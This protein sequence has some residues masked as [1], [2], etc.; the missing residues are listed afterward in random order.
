[1]AVD[2][3]Y[4]YDKQENFIGTL[5][6][7]N[8]SMCPF[9]ADGRYERLDNTASTL[10][11][12]TLLKHSSGI[13]S[14][15]ENEGFVV[16]KDRDGKFV[17]YKIIIA[18]EDRTSRQL[19]VLAVGSWIELT[20]EMIEPFENVKLSAKQQLDYF[21]QNTRWRS[22][23]VAYNGVKTMSSDKMMTVLEATQRLRTTFE[24]EPRFRI[25]MGVNGEITGRYCD[26]L[27][28]RGIVHPNRFEI[29]KDV[30]LLKRKID[31]T[32]L[33]TALYGYGQQAEGSN[34]DTP[35]DFSGV[36][37]S[38]SNGDPVNKPFG[39]KWVG[40]DEALAKYGGK[41]KKHRFGVHESQVQGDANSLLQHTWEVLQRRSVPKV[42]YEVDL[43]VLGDVGIGDTINIVDQKDDDN[44]LYLEARV[45]E[46]EGPVSEDK[47]GK[48]ILGNYRELQKPDV[49]SKIKQLEKI[50]GERLLSLVIASIS[51]SAGNI[52]K[53]GIG[54]T[55][56]TANAFL[57]GLE[58]DAD[59]TKYT[60]TWNKHD[61][62]GNLVPSFIK[63][64]KTITVN[65]NEI[66][67]KA[68][69][70]VT[71]RN[72]KVSIPAEITISNVF[73]G[74]DGKDG[75]TP[76][77][78]VDYFDGVDGQNGKDGSSSF[79]WIRYSQNADGSNMTTDPTGAKYIGVS[80]TK[81]STAPTNN[82][83]YQWSLVKGT[84]GVKG[85]KGADGQT[86]YLHIKYSND[87]GKTF[88]ANSGETVGDWIGTYVDF[89]ELDSTNVTDYT[90]NKVKGEQ[91]PQ[92]IPGPKGAD[93]QTLYT[94]I[95]YANDANG[96]GMSDY[97]DG[98]SYIG[99]AYN[100][101]TQT[102]STNPADYQWALIEG[103]QGVKGTDGKTYYTWLKYADSPTSGMSD[104]PTGKKYMGIAYNKTTST[105]STN[106]ADYSWSLI[107]GPQ[108]PQGVQGPKGADGQSL[109]TWVKYAD[110]PTAGMSDYPTNKKYIGL[111]YNKTTPVES[112]NYADYQWAKIEGDQGAPGAPGTTTYTWVKYAD[113]DKGA[114]MSDSPV[115]KRYLGLAYNKTTQTESTNPADYSWS[116]LYDNVQVGGVNLISNSKKELTEV[117]IGRDGV[118]LPFIVPI[119]DETV[120][121]GNEVTFSIYI[122]DI[123]AD[124]HLVLRLDWYRSDRT[125]GLAMGTEII[126]EEGRYSLTA[127]IP[128]DT[129]FTNI[130]ARIYPNNWISD[131]KIKYKN[132]QLE[133][134]NI[135]T[136]YSPSIADVEADAQAKANKAEQ[137]ANT[138]TNTVK[139]QLQKDI[140]D[141]NNSVS[142]L[143]TYV[144]G[145]F[146]D[147]II[148]NAEATA[149]EKYLNTVNAEKTDLDG[150]YLQIYN[151]T[152]LTNTTIK[153]DLYNKK[154][155]YNSAHT[156]LINA[157]NTAIADG[158]TTLAEKQDVDSKFASYRTALAG[159]TT[160]FEKALTSISQKQADTAKTTAI[161]IAS[162]DATN[163]AN[164]ALSSANT[165]TNNKDTALRDGLN[166]GAVAVNATGIHGMLAAGKLDID[167]AIQTGIPEP[168]LYPL[169]KYID[170]NS[171]TVETG[172]TTFMY[173]TFKHSKRYITFRIA[174][175]WAGERNGQEGMGKITG[176]RCDYAVATRPYIENI[177]PGSQGSFSNESPLFNGNSYE[178][179]RNITVDMGAPNNG[180]KF[181]YLLFKGN[182]KDTTNN[183]YVHAFLRCV[184][185]AQ[186]D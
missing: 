122:K 119:G 167:L 4:L 117:T 15:I 152:D 158:K 59:G 46:L 88:T 179:A 124:E 94:W 90:W 43:A 1:M 54:T 123:P 25:E 56:L 147:G 149:I 70:V 174:G 128:N 104:S 157:I 84:D 12:K 18:E 69:Y 80:T 39:Q 133:K 153:T 91:G 29:G 6:N 51:S 38:K 163:K 99:L 175:R 107:Q 95:K 138:Y 40:S 96:T 114:G 100:K 5:S 155:A 148:S 50:L 177:I 98:K 105:E 144:D 73:D 9:F 173:W 78:G 66:D 186:H 77:K 178:Q 45:L 113:D 35:L 101:T 76:I 166:T 28:R 97:P 31:T 126:T 137:N 135:A 14:R 79:L 22:G 171:V 55:E 172:Y 108:G 116:P 140:T 36:Q 115:G 183:N 120:L 150:R 53:N 111:A 154:V 131:Y 185:V 2:I 141:V 20:K 30:Q 41:D 93:G 27:E 89:T 125:Y 145:A 139:T 81:T 13:P 102:E 8:S 110:S 61:K 92:G 68:T 146:K 180:L 160:A 10:E 118:T 19:Y 127:K 164:S 87:G 86:S 7:K 72:D 130:R 142:A 134:G 63:T 21:L 159:L 85:E 44:E 52:F 182:L 136:A 121:H 16:F 106:Y 168:N 176:G 65:A 47:K 156:N 32:E 143:D 11:F 162:T 103:P 23:Q 184:Y 83:D 170:G 169:V 17:Q 33:V 57:S 74:A 112:T 37:W 161:N 75:Y 24:L 58:Y 34:V 67:E 129:S 165:Y 26:L 3:L 60:Y 109:Y 71:I 82:T 64:G 151:N 181:I 42:T 48:A 49:D 62:T 132:E